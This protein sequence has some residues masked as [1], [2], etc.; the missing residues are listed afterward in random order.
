MADD[1]RRVRKGGPVMY[2]F[3]GFTVRLEAD[4]FDRLNGSG[5]V[6]RLRVRGL[7]DARASE[8]WYEGGGWEPYYRGEDPDG[9]L[10][11]ERNALLAHLA[12]L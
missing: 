5:P 11:R 1:P 6:R 7:G 2:P 10:E 4:R 12:A 9:S 3:G 8:T